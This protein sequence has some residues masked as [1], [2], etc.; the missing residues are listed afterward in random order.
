MSDTWA[1]TGSFHY[2]TFR[3]QMWPEI[4]SAHFHHWID[5]G[6]MGRGS[7]TINSSP[8]PLMENGW[9]SMGT[10]FCKG[11]FGGLLT[12]YQNMSLYCG[13]LH[14]I[15]I[16]TA[17]M[18]ITLWGEYRYQIS[19]IDPDKHSWTIIF[20]RVEIFL[21]HTLTLLLDSM[22]SQMICANENWES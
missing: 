19:Y 22:T 2:I 21:S 5:I 13:S 1:R 20:I 6:L 14:M 12:R 16:S 3:I 4:G 17:V 7:N 10:F 9:I 15:M 18:H 8:K 11:K